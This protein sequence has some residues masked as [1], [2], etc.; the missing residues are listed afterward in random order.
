MKYLFPALLIMVSLSGFGCL[1]TALQYPKEYSE[2]QINSFETALN[3]T[4]KTIELT[5][6][7]LSLSLDN[8]T[9]QLLLVDGSKENITIASEAVFSGDNGTVKNL[10]ELKDGDLIKIF[11]TRDLANLNITARTIWAVGEQKIIITSP[12]P[13]ATVTS[14]LVVEG[15][16]NLQ[17]NNLFWRIK[18]NLQETKYSGFSEFYPIQNSF[19][20]LRLEIFLPTL[21]TQ[22]FILE[23]FTKNSQNKNEENLSSLPLHLL[24]VN[25]SNFTVFFSNDRLN[26]SGTCNTVFPVSRTITETSALGRASL[27]EILNG[28]TEKERYEGY[29]SS[30]PFGTTITS[31]VI[32]GGVATV[33]ISQ[34][35]EKTSTCERQRAEEQIKKTLLQISSVKSVVILVE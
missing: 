24:S 10:S 32:S 11:G 15:F 12:K 19:A 9:F 5:G 13:L 2:F 16:S 34:D 14:P 8:K 22:D 7:V 27:L 26:S 25:T 1:E 17:T 28:P 20:P 21:E 33:T 4:N 23:I 30:L 3:E 31:F 6:V 18:N 35:L 29:R